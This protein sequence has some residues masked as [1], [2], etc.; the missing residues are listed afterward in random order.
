MPL[1]R[2][3]GVL[4]MCYPEDR[5]AIVADYTR[6]LR[7]VIIDVVVRSV[8]TLELL[9]LSF[10][11]PEDTRSQ[12]LGLPTWVPDITALDI[13]Q[14]VDSAH[15]SA[16]SFDASSRANHPAWTTL[17]DNSNLPAAE[18]DSSF[19][20]S[21]E[22]EILCLYGCLCDVVTYADIM[23]FVPQYMGY[24][25]DLAAENKA[26]RARVSIATF[27]KWERIAVAEGMPPINSG[28]SESGSGAPV[29]DV[30][31]SLPGGRKE[32]FWRSLSCDSAVRGT[33]PLPRDYGERYETLVG[34]RQP[35]DG[36]KA[37]DE[38]EPMK[39]DW[40]REYGVHAVAKCHNKS[41]FVTHR[42]RMGV[43]VRGA[44]KGDIV[45]IARGSQVPYVVRRV[46]NGTF[47]FVGEAY[48]H[49]VMDGEAV[50]EAAGLGWPVIKFHLR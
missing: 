6:Q 28:S 40:V 21:R 12:E 38:F 19:W 44:K 13:T 39:N 47:R 1:D 35:P 31:A 5:E 20:L 10:V 29:V 4:G 42:G 15:S 34:Q 32:A 8:P 11:G 50:D 18:S 25:T 41:F 2:I 45:M 9:F 24:D 46:G 48:V 43:G 16:H 49:G 30:Y 33:R 26:Q 23:P 36:V 7:D 37:G 3:Y 14:R 17:F 27:Q 22:K